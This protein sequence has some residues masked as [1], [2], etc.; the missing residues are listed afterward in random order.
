VKKCK[1]Y[2]LNIPL[3]KNQ[4]WCTL[5]TKNNQSFFREKL[6][7]GI[8]NKVLGV[9]IHE[10]NAVKGEK[11]KISSFRNL[12]FLVLDSATLTKKIVG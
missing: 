11:R 2:F 12:T 4:E 10:G 1:S 5:Q 8:S 9:K 3:P 6:V 7:S